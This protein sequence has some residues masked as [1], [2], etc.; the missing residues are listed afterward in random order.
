MPMSSKDSAFC[1]AVLSPKSREAL[2]DLPTRGR[3]EEEQRDGEHE[4]V[5]GWRE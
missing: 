3:G 2:G 1:D 5:R 4:C